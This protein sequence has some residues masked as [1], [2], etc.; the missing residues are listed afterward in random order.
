M[1]RVYLLFGIHSYKR[2]LMFMLAI[3]KGLYKWDHHRELRTDGRPTLI[4]RIVFFLSRQ[5]LVLRFA[6]IHPIRPLSFIR[7]DQI[8][9]VFA[10]LLIK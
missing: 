5:E 7:D 8:M 2:D 6:N 10:F 4:G 1:I 3:L 9:R